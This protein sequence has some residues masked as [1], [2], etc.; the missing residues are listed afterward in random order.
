MSPPCS[1]EGLQM[2]SPQTL[3]LPLP[4]VAVAVAE[5]TPK[6]VKWKTLD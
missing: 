5:K 6:M 3:V 2:P 4:A 1:P